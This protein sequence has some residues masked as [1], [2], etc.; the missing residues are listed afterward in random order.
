MLTLGTGGVSLFAVQFARL[1]GARVIATSS[2]DDKLNGAPAL[3]ATDGI[4]YKTKPDWDKS[5]RELTGG[6]GV[7]VVVEVGGAGT[8][9]RRSEP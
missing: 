5:V 9:P 4:N 7:D 1:A 8:F 2:S 6:V 3:G